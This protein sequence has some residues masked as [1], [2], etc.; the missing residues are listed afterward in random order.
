MIDITRLLDRLAPE[1]DG[2]SALRLRTMTV[3]AINVDETVDL[4]SGSTTIPDVSRLDSAPVAVGSPVQVLTGLG[5][6]LVLGP[7][8]GPTPLVPIST[9]H[10]AATAPV[11]ANPG[12]SNLTGCAFT[13]VTTQTNAVAIVHLVVDWDPNGQTGATYIGFIALDGVDISNPQTVFENSTSASN[14][15]TLGQNYRV[16]I[17]TAGSH[18]IQ[19]RVQRA[20]G[21]G[22]VVANMTH[23]TLTGTVYQFG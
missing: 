3:A 18:T 4:T 10:Q 9:H 12:P 7:T 1:V 2:A 6:M 16:P 5:Q 13:F 15:A 19:A 20:S 11:T 17:P 22:L 21:T 14:R 8:N 23:S